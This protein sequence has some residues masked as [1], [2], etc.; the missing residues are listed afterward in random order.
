M[1]FSHHIYL[2][3]LRSPH[4]DLRNTFLPY[5]LYNPSSKKYFYTLYR[6]SGCNTKDTPLLKILR[7]WRGVSLRPPLFLI[8]W[9]KIFPRLNFSSLR[10]GEVSLVLPWACKIQ[11]FLELSN[12]QKYGFLQATTHD[13]YIIYG[14]P[15]FGNMLKIMKNERKTV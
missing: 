14:V 7:F 1:I 4:P 13:S 10:R 8:K 9:M 11:T 2:F 12:L 6:L 5:I 3:S 15:S